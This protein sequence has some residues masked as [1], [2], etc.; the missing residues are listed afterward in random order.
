M[1]K[2]DLKQNMII[3]IKNGVKFIVLENVDTFL[4]GHQ[5]LFFMNSDGYLIGDSYDEDLKCTNGKS[6][7]PKLDIVKVMKWKN[8]AYIN[9]L[10]EDENNAEF[11]VLWERPQQ[12]NWQPWEL[13]VLKH[14]P[15]YFNKITRVDN[16]D[17]RIRNY[18]SGNALPLRLNLPSLLSTKT[19]EPQWLN[20]DKE[21]AR[22]GMKR[23]KTEGEAK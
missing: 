19:N 4:Y 15:P 14:I 2:S 8:F 13:E 12:V 1:K 10:N 7:Q 6:C 17:I 22:Y 3:E 18:L 5:N 16:E 23:E 21:L 20:I 11:E 9:H